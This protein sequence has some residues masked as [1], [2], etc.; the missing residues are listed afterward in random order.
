MTGRLIL[1]ILTSLSTADAV[2][3]QPFPYKFSYLT[4]DEGLSHTDVNDIA[5]DSKGYIWLATNFGLDRYDGYAI[6]KFYNSNV[7]LNNAFKNRVIKLFPDD[8]GKIWLSTEGGLQCFNPNTETFTDFGMDKASSSP[9]FWEFFKP[10]GDL[11]YGYLDYTFKVFKINGNRLEEQKISLPMGVRFFDMKP[12]RHGVLH[13]ASNKGIWRLDDRR[14]VVQVPVKGLPDSDLSRVFFDNQNNLLLASENKVFLVRQKQSGTGDKDALFVNKQVMIHG[15]NLVLEISVGKNGDYWINTRNG[16]TRLDHQ[17]N[18]IQTINE[19]SAP[20]NLNSSA[21]LSSFIDR[22]NCL[23][24]GTSGGGVNYCDLNQ[25][26]FYTIHNVPGQVNSLSGNHI[27]SVLEDGDNLWIGTNANGLNLYNLKTQRFSFYNTY[28]APVRLKNDEITALTFDNDHNLWI[29]SNAGIEILRPDR[30]TLWKPA[31]YDG[32]P[33]INI[34]TLAKDCFGNIWFGNLDN[35]GV[36]WKDGAG[37]HRVKMYTEGHFILPDETKPQLLVSSR[38]GVKQLLIDGEGNISKAFY[39]K[40]SAKTGSLS[41]DYITAI[42]RQNDSTYWVGTIG[43]ALNRFSLD[44]KD[45]SHKFRSFGSQ[46]GVFNDVES[47]ETDNAG[48]IWMG[49][50]G[51]ERLD[52]A[53]GKVIRYDKND[54]LQGNSFKIRASYKGADGRLYFGGIN[55]LNYFYPEQIRANKIEAKPILTD[56]LINNKRPVYAAEDSLQNTLHEAVGY[57]NEVELNYLQNNFVVAFSAMH[58]AN[59]MKCKYRYKLAGFDNE[60]NYTDGR[61]PTAAYSNLDYK[62]YKLIVEA[63][64]NDGVWSKNSAEIA[65]LVTPPWWKSVFAKLVYALLVLSA[66]SGIYIYQARWY[67]LKREMEVRAI[68]EKKREEIHAQREALSQQQLAFF[69]NISHEFRTPLTLILGPLE[70][71]ISQNH[72]A[73]LD[74]SYQLMLRNAKRLFNLISE[75]MNFRKVADSMIKLQV[76]RLKINPFCWNLITE[77]QNVADSKDIDLE[78]ID[79]TENHADVPL[80]GL[81]DVHIIE[82]IL[83]NLLNNSFKYTQRGGQVCFEI[84]TDIK[85]FKPSFNAGFDLLNESHRAEKYLYFRVA[86]SG[87]G[88]S[89]ETITH[90]FDRYYRISRDHL[91]SGIGLAL[92][93]SLTQLHKGDIYVYSERN[94]GTEIIIGIPLGDENY[95]EAERATSERGPEVRLEAVDHSVLMPMTEADRERISAPSPVDKRILI[96]DDNEELGTFLRQAFEKN[97]YIYQ[98]EDGQTALEIAIE[99]VPDLII[100]DVMM[101]GMNGIE[102]CKAVKDRFETSHIPFII[103]SAK[104][105]LATKIEGMESGADYYFA[106]PL[107]IDLL[108]LT[109]HNIFEQSAKLKSRFTNNHLSEATELV[110]SEKDKSFFQTLLKLIEDH[111]EDPELDVDFLC[112]HLY[113]SR[114][115]L[116]QKIKS[117]TDQSVGDF[118]RTVRLKKAI[119]IMTHEDIPLSKVVERIGLQSS[120]S[121]SKIFKKEY[122]KSP[123]QFMQA[124]RQNPVLKTDSNTP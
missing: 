87:I 27:R 96:V 41:S 52:P 112:K 115:K 71:L 123:L 4:V 7:P 109:V 65:I 83:L 90:I 111:I 43:G 32:F 1:L 38:Q 94:K 61:R 120:S 86:D 107:S 24:I 79:H 99:K 21:S 91:G 110:H 113:I 80:T 89:S 25:K 114:T 13:F 20:N 30:K 36:I 75:L 44:T 5:Q 122:G 97:Y 28:N 33:K 45:N 58:F 34:N 69:T 3:C 35:F 102:L 47:I 59:P 14:E 82:K 64:N 117:I 57:D 119:Q 31:G 121:F 15:A 106:K 18:F 2:S 9:V 67:R 42:S 40:A 68:N 78:F 84:F 72:N 29:G 39:Y 103:L 76:Q 50:D 49:G 55:G 73:V 92:V 77:F 95:S 26:L 60:W 93:K 74:N 51:L 85:R 100:S 46:Y 56:I 54:G 19:K 37:Q 10:A 116:Y 101:P 48:S 12:D 98:A 6:R 81:L 17:L 105:A 70:N 63:T 62:A 8:D 104:D 108:L 11:I 66:I 118:I 16:L 22:S 23:W 124:L 88:I 53:N